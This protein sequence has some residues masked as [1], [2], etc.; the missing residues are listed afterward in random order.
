MTL[1]SKLAC[2][3]VLLAVAGCV[4]VNSS[5]M[6][7]ARAEARS[8]FDRAAGR[9]PTI[10]TL[11]AMA[12]LLAAKGDDEQARIVLMHILARD[13]QYSPAYNDL[14]ALHQRE[15]HEA[16]ARAALTAGIQANPNDAVLHNNMGLC[17][18]QAEEYDLALE[19]FNHAVEIDPLND[20]YQGNRALT[21][22]LMGD[23]EEAMK[24]YSTFL[25]MSEARAN[26]RLIAQ[27]RERK[28]TTEFGGTEPTDGVE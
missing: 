15:G 8:E 18:L 19:R 2:V 7:M 23:D 3:L 27:I 25:P 13:P 12:T 14:A 4:P 9:P 17:H 16:E 5:D 26:V 22:G 10:R 24:I 20:K 1:P 21:V 11:H 6:E 28:A